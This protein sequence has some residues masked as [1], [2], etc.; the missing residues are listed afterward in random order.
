MIRAVS[1]PLEPISI[2]KPNIAPT[3]WRTYADTRDKRYFFEGA[4]EPMLLWVD[5]DELDLSEK[6]K[7]MVLTLNETWTE[8]V[9]D[10]SKNFVP[11]KP[12]EPLEVDE[13]HERKS[14]CLLT[15]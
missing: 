3:L 2:S 12:F 13:V 4:K 7:V 15:Q 14:S 6:G 1:V 8:R 5:M 11:A 9:G 10:M